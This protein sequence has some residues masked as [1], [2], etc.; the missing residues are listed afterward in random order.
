MNIKVLPILALFLSTCISPSSAITPKAVKGTLDLRYLKETE[1]FEI[2]LNGD[3][4]FYWNQILRPEDFQSGKIKPEYYGKVPSYWTDYK[5]EVIKTEKFGYGTY[6]LTLLL[7]KGYKRPLAFDVPVFDS[8]YDLFINGKYYA[9]NG[10][11]GKSKDDSKPGYKRNFFRYDPKSDSVSIVINVANYSHRRG[12]F[13]TPMKFGTFDKVQKQMA[14]IWATEWATISFLLGFGLFF[15]FFFI[16]YPKE[17]VVGYFSLGIIGLALRPLFTSNFLIYNFIDLSWSWTVR[18]EYLTLFLTILGVQWFIAYLYPSRPFRLIFKIMTVIFMIAAIL[19]LILPVKIFSYS[20]IITYAEMVFLMI[21]TISSS[22]YNLFKRRKFE[23]FYFLAFA[24]FGGGA[25]HDMMVSMGQAPD[26]AGYVMTYIII[27]FV[28]IQAALLLYKWVLSYVEIDKLKS[29]FEFINRNLEILVD[30]RTQELKKRNTEIEEQTNT[31][32]LQNKELS[33]TIQLKNKIFSVIAH[34]LRSPVV[35]ILYML[36]LLKEKEYK[37]RYDTFA[38]S[39]IQYAQMVISLLE[40]MLVWGRGQE[41]KIK[42]APEMRNLADIV[43][44]NLSIFKETSDKKEIAVNFTQVG[45]PMA[46]FDKDL[47][48]IIIRN[49]L[50]NAVKYTPRGGRISILLKDRSQDGNGML[51]KICDNGIGIPE[52]KLRHLLTSEEITS[53]PGTENEKGTGLGLKL[54]A[55]LVK[56]N[57]GTITVE[58]RENEGSCFSIILPSI[59]S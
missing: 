29:D 57:K 27:V 9:S 20:V 31:I 33:E 43:L 26:G 11:V 30:Q 52:D 48:D 38:N 18:M 47:L 46:Y 55:E 41:D 36:N 3:W 53:T 56:L 42:I 12:G 4:E 1:S 17:K 5:N 15:F 44:T 51:L 34:D 40:N 39:S 21:Y 37:E 2:N 49:L 7:P 14:R 22:I 54:C 6:R 59:P 35:N 19:T 32:A 45:S 24:V 50:S 13:W 8:S 16:I 58:S 10:V 28:F 25:I 23:I